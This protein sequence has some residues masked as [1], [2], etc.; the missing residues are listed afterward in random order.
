[1]DASAGHLSAYIPN[2]LQYTGALNV[3]PGHS[4]I[5]HS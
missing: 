1:M 5:T 3:E 2:L 4:A